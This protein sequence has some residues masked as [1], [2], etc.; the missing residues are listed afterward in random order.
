MDFSF[1]EELGV[2]CKRGFTVCPASSFS[3]MPATLFQPVILTGILHEAE[4]QRA[5]KEF[6]RRISADSV[7][8]LWDMQQKTAGKYTVQSLVFPEGS[9]ELWAIF[10]PRLCSNKEDERFSLDRLC[11]IMEDL[12]APDGCPW[13]SVQT[14]ETLRTYLIQEAYEAVDAIDHEDMENLKEELGDILYQIVFHARVAEE[15]GLFSMQDVIDGISNKMVKRHPHVFG[16]M[17]SRETAELLGN[18]EERKMREK[19]RQHLLSGLSRSLPS[20]LFACIMQKKV[21]SICGENAEKMEFLKN[22]FEF[23]WRQ[24]MDKA[25]AGASVG[26]MEHCFGR[27]LFE[28]AAAIRFWGVEPELAL[29]RFN[30]LFAEQFGKWEDA[31]IQDGRLPTQAEEKDLR[32]LTE[33]LRN[34]GLC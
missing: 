8:L 16:S 25:N 6:L 18:W 33:H 11:R 13:D 9:G 28:M 15:E 21:S 17:T 32:M 10:D 4:M 5:R 31:L 12:R 1:L 24:A 20:L 22:H 19:H 30:L 26:E 3:M 34:S 2:D 27:A 14:H 29:H 23:S 7:I